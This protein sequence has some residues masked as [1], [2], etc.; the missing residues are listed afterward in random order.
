MKYSLKAPGM[1]IA[2]LDGYQI[3]KAPVQFKVPVSFE[4]AGAAVDKLTITFS[5]TKG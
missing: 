4:A 2:R 1:F 5:H 3:E